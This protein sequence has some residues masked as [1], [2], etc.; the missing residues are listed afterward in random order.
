MKD[1]KFVVLC[2]DDDHDLL[3]SLRLV[4]ESKGHLVQTADSGEAGLARY[5]A[6]SPDVVIVDLMMEAAD[7]GITV[8][9]KLKELGA[10]TPIYMLSTVGD[11]L[12]RNADFHELGLAGVLQKPIVP[13]VLLKTLSPIL[14]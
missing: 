9:R 6:C 10:T 2:I 4:L 13:D 5:K 8:A 11:A 14:K 12:T 3:E 1:G 7:S